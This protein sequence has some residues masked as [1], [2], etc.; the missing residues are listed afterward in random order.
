MDLDPEDQ[1]TCHAEA[2]YEDRAACLAS[3]EADLLVDL[4]AACDYDP[5]DYLAA[6]SNLDREDEAWDQ[7]AEVHFALAYLRVG[8]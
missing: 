3:P 7:T 4:A 8:D 2:S 5:A 1:A 6:A